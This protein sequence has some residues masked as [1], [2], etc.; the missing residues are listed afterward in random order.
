MSQPHVEALTEHETY[1]LLCAYTVTHADPDFVH[2][3]VFDTFAAQTATA[4]T[5]P[6]ALAMSLVGLYLAAEKGYSGRKVQHVHTLLARGGRKTW[7]VCA[8]PEHRGAIRVGDVVAAPPGRERDAL[9][10]RWCASVWTALAGNR[11]AVVE[12]LRT[13]LP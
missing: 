3:H 9:I 11:D 8:L 6:I 2:Q 13:S 7:P 12:L 5:K 4:S 10:H 1:D